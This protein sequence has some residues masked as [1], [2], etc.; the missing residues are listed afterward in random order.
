MKIIQIVPREELRLYAALVKKDRHSQK[1]SRNIL[2]RERQ[3]A[4][5]DQMAA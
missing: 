3:E 2:S 5:F 1:G 4:E